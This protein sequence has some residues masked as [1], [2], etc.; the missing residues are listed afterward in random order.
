MEARSQ[1]SWLAAQT[2]F[3]LCGD[4]SNTMAAIL[5]HLPDQAAFD[6]PAIAAMAQAFDEACSALHI[7]AGDGLGRE[8]I[9]ARIIDLA[10]DGVIDANLLR[11][12]VLREARLSL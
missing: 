9:A 1:A 5:A 7:F 10:R 8:A 2:S 11:D 6:P 4:G 3:S 12:R